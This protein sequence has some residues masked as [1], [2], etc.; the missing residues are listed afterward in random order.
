MELS[1]TVPVAV[2]NLHQVDLP[3]CH[4]CDGTIV[5]QRKSSHV[6]MKIWIENWIGWNTM[7][8]PAATAEVV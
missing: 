6:R 8:A 5:V 1:R 3:V 7:L 2:L 4:S